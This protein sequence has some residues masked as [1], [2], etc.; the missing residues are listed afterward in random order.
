MSNLALVIGGTGRQGGATA[1]HLLKRG[2]QV[3]ALVRDI[4]S[5]RRTA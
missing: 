5:P 4:R 3:R 1:R 2:R